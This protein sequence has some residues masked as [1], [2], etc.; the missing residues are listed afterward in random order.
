MKISQETYDETLLENEDIFELSPN[1]AVEETISQFKQQSITNLES[2]I[3]TSHPLSAKGKEERIVRSNFVSLLNKLD[4]FVKS[5]GTIDI[6]INVEGKGG[7]DNSS[8]VIVNI[9]EEIHGF[10]RRGITKKVSEE[11]KDSSDGDGNGNSDDNENGNDDSSSTEKGESIYYNNPVPFLTMAH[12][13]SSLYTF[14]NLLSIVEFPKVTDAGTSTSTS[15]NTI[16]TP[17]DDQTRIL[18]SA[19]KLLIT[20]LCPTNKNEKDVKMTFK[21]AFVCMDRM[22]GLAAMYMTLMKQ[23]QQQHQNEGE[24][25]KGENEVDVNGDSDDTMIMPF[26]ETLTLIIQC[27]MN[28]CKNCERNK[29]SFV[30]CLKAYN[31]SKSIEFLIGNMF[32]TL[33]NTVNR[34]N[35]DDQALSRGVREETVQVS[36]KKRESTIGI[37]STLMKLTLSLYHHQSSSE[38]RTTTKTSSSLVI[39]MTE[40][41]KLISVLCRFD[42]FR[43]SESAN[44]ANNHASMVDS[45]YGG[46]SSAHDH[47]LE[48]NREGIIPTLHEL[49]LL[50]LE[51]QKRQEKMDT[52]SSDGDS[53]NRYDTYAVG[54]AAAA[55][56]A[57]RVLAV[58][59]EI[60]QAL[61]AVGI[62]KSIKVALDMGVV[63]KKM[64]EEA[65]DGQCNS[66]VDYSDADNS[67]SDNKEKIFEEDNSKDDD[68][69]ADNDNLPTTNDRSED[70]NQKNIDTKRQQL[71]SGAIGLIRN[72]CGNDEIKTTLCLGTTTSNG[73]N[74]LTTI[75]VPSILPS[76]IQGMNIYKK[77]SSIQEHGCGTLAA[78]ALRK[79]SNALR[80]LHEDGASSILTAMKL[81]PSNVLVQRQGALAIRNIVSRLVANTS[82]LE[83]L[84]EGE[85]KTQGRSDS[86]AQEG[87]LQATDGNSSK[88]IN[89]RD[90]FLD[91]GAEVILRGITGRHQGSVDEAYA[92]LRDLGCP[93]SMVKYDAEKQTTTTRTVMFGDIDVKSTFRPVYEESS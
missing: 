41:C 15:S 91:L 77:N 3:V 54:L 76:I 78:M 16:A 87:C 59:D 61:V 86:K 65:D 80:I 83:S 24:C 1:E 20:L 25:C 31:V 89:V 47:V 23:Q 90:I 71:T 37:L 51:Q 60:V 2:Y 93:V 26:I 11:T 12:S 73:S 13:T 81:F 30:R 21:D 32:D 39:L 29:V 55:M 22:V 92:A 48:F 82:A 69:V 49:I 19:L 64:E 43:T 62:L 58:N 84:Q 40:C 63:A 72:L 70:M 18:Q 27:I 46:V 75:V 7:N 6:T 50:S 35:G 14:M 74:D 5:D 45:S 28:A 38:S 79:P 53:S 42:D 4:S 57:T 88:S 36:K 9:I 10:C 68:D 66:N 52:T 85:K 56:S 33:R 8:S 17:T 67:E 34:N 44:S